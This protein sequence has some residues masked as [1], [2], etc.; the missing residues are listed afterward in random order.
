MSVLIGPIGRCSGWLGVEGGDPEDVVDG[1]GYLEPGPGAVAASVAELSAAGD[2]L[3]PTEWFLDS[4][5]DPLADLVAAVA[6]R[7]GVDRRVSRVLR[8][9]RGEAELANPG[10]EALGVVA[11]VTGDGPSP[12]GLGEPS[13]H[14]G[15]GR[16]FGVAVGDAQLGVDDQR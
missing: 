5:A 7:S 15:G 12:C 6:C 1:W 3:D 8:D 14:L 16:A 10:D 11:L 2:G 9:V 13:E 4:F